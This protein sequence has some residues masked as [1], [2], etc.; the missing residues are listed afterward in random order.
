MRDAV[1]LMAV[2]TKLLDV[3]VD[4]CVLVNFPQVSGFD[5]LGQMRL[6]RCILLIP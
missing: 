6:L 1:E 3:C 4:T 5:L 2:Q